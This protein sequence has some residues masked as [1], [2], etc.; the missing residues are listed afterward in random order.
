[1]ADVSRIPERA[2]EIIERTFWDRKPAVL[3]LDCLKTDPHL[4][5]FGLEQSLNAT[6][7]IGAQKTLYIGF[8]HERTHA[9]WIE[10]IK[11]KQAVDMD[12]GPGFDGQTVQAESDGR[13]YLK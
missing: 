10:Y 4:S 7:R 3:A 5:H 2:Y 13:V 9:S 6:Y 8:G 11:Q 12:I 1:M